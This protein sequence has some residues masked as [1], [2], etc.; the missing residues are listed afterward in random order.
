MIVPQECL[1]YT[2]VFMAVKITHVAALV[3]GILIGY[4][5]ERIG[6]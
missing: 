4:F 3:V 1:E 5:Y 6:K 2:T